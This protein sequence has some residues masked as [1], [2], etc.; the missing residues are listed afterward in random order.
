MKEKVKKKKEKDGK[1]WKKKNSEEIIN[2]CQIKKRQWKWSKDK[3]KKK[4]EKG[5]RFEFSD[6]YFS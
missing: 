5:F 3:R 6:R 4:E 1:E 2:D